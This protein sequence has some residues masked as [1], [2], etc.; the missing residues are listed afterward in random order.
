LTYAIL[1]NFKGP[2]KGEGAKTLGPPKKK[3]E[4][5]RTDVSAGLKQKL[6]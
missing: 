1:G 2:K 5:K 4:R 6:I 3:E